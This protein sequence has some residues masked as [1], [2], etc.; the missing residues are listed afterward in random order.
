[1]STENFDW[2]AYL[3]YN[4]DL[5]AQGIVT[6][7]AAV[8]HYINIGHKEGR[9]YN[10]IMPEMESFDWR[11]YLQ[12]NPDLYRTGINTEDQA[13]QHYR[14]IGSKEGRHSRAPTPHNESLVVAV[15]KLKSYIEKKHVTDSISIESTNFVIYHMEDIESSSNSM[16]VTFNNVKLFASAVRQNKFP[17]TTTASEH[18][19]YWINAAAVSQHPLADLFPIDY[20]NVALVQWEVDGGVMTSH[21]DT[22][23]R[24]A[25]DIMGAFSAVF[26]SNSGVRGPFEL[27][28]QG[29]WL[30][31]YR[32]LLQPRRVVLAGATAVCTPIPHVQTHFVAIK[33]A[34]IPHIL[35][36]ARDTYLLSKVWV[37]MDDFF[38]TELTRIVSNLGLE[39]ASMM[40]LR[41]LNNADYRID[42][43][44]SSK[45]KEYN[46]H[47]ASMRDR[48]HVHPVEVNFVRWSG[49]GLGAKG[50][51]C[52]KA[53][54]TDIDAVARME[55]QLA[56]LAADEPELGLELSEALTGGILHDLYQSYTDDFWKNRNTTVTVPSFSA[57]MGREKVR[58]TGDRILAEL[59]DGKAS[60]Q[61]AKVCFLIK[62]GK[63]H[64]PSLTSSSKAKYGMI[65]LDLD[66]HIRCKALLRLL[67]SS[68]CPS[69][70]YR[71]SD[72]RFL[73]T[74]LLRQSNPHWKAF[75]YL[76]ERSA[77]SK[78][79][80]TLLA[81]YQDARLELVGT[82]YTPRSRVSVLIFVLEFGHDL[83]LIFAYCHYCQGGGEG[84]MLQAALSA[85]LADAEC[86]W[87]SVSTAATAYGSEVVDRA[88]LPMPGGTT[89][90]DILLAPLDSKHFA[91]QGER[92]S[93][94]ISVVSL[95]F[96]RSCGSS[97]YVTRQE[98]RWDQR[99]LGIEA[100]LR[101]NLLTYTVQPVPHPGR[102]DFSAAFL[103]KER[104]VAENLGSVPV[105]GY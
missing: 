69:S 35:A 71:T 16:A 68:C 39:S 42:C 77:F 43:G 8:S 32:D 11:S 25:A 63:Q 95:N 52:N 47:V 97:D 66:G 61:A 23:Q 101:H 37:S 50:Y 53:I 94:F 34:L 87:I 4:K 12:L 44:N 49:E 93:P 70:R 98:T 45:S 73:I 89:P 17:A 27:R 57:K 9:R 103:S 67:C 14:S 72:C 90:A 6:E 51:L 2:K 86:R 29:K 78:R 31:P 7:A 5:T 21:I 22:L 20:P 13:W 54:A 76:T 18:A 41:R 105:V 26:L 60:G 38:E 55:V 91:Q 1:V 64:D 46:S 3:H 88:L 65:T 80:R 79:L 83:L 96:L 99:C 75:Y 15:A 62:T 56:R 74:A 58:D 92:N 24:L 30:G 82:D 84:E 19:F 85:A 59:S 33:T 104:I 81:G 48:C 10:K 40:H 36:S 100:M 28:E 102:V